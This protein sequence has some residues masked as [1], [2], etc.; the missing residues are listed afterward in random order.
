MKKTHSHYCLNYDE[1][2]NLTKKKA[3]TAHNNK[4]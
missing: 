1:L 4:K 2:R 3:A